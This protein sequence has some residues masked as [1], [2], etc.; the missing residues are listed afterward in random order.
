MRAQIEA[1]KRMNEK[2][3][4]RL[5]QKLSALQRKK[6]GFFGKMKKRFMRPP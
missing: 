1:M 3:V 6:E 2:E 4:E 5:R